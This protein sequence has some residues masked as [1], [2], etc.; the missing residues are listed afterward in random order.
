M[1]VSRMAPK[2]SGCLI[3]LTAKNNTLEQTMSK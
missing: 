1:D 3:A 2:V